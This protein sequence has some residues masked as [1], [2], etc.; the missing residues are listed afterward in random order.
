MQQ[1]GLTFT[2]AATPR[3]GRRAHEVDYFKRPR[4]P[5]DRDL[6]AE[7]H[8]PG[9]RRHAEVVDGEVVENANGDPGQHRYRMAQ[10]GGVVTRS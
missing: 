4:M 3:A 8:R 7:F 1:G 6:V 10:Y 2:T 9:D 5:F